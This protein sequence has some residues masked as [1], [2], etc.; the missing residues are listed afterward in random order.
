MWKTHGFPRTRIYKWWVKIT[1]MLVTL[2]DNYL[3]YIYIYISKNTVWWYI[4][5]RCLVLYFQTN[6]LGGALQK[7]EFRLMLWTYRRL[8]RLKCA[9]AEW[10]NWTYFSLPPQNGPTLW[11]R[12]IM[13]PS[14]P[15]TW[16]YSRP[17]RYWKVAVD[18][19]S[20]GKHKN[21]HIQ[22]IERER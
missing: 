9:F 16:F 4:S 5:L 11:D 14:I 19:K 3:Q 6:L 18:N 1:S 10:I 13:K 8:N 21:K 12:L 7:S 20:W 2:E 22:W 17:V 15:S